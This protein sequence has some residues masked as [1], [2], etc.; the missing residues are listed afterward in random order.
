[1]PKRSKARRAKQDPPT[2]PRKRRKRRRSSISEPPAAELCVLGLT[3]E[4]WS[5]MLDPCHRGVALR[6]AEEIYTSV[7]NIDALMRTAQNTLIAAVRAYDPVR[8]LTFVDYAHPRMSRA[9]HEHA[10]EQQIPERFMRWRK[11]LII[12][13]AI[14][15][16]HA[17]C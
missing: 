1:M 11:D 7:V 4:Q 15:E 17:G 9:M 14:S 13:V 6:L 16:E 3:Q 5:L 8:G 2:A 12:L 10:R